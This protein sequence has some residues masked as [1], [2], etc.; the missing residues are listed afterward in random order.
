MRISCA[1]FGSCAA[2]IDGH[3]VRVPWLANVQLFIID[4]FFDFT[5]VQGEILRQLIPRF[6]QTIVNLNNDDSNPEIF[7]PFQETIGQLQS[8][9]TFDTVHTQDYTATDR[10]LVIAPR[11]PFQSVEVVMK[12]R[13]SRS[14]SRSEIRYLECGDRDTEIRTIARE[15]KR[16]VLTE[17]YDLA[18]IALVVRERAAYASTISR[19]LLEESLPCNLELRVDAGDVPANRAALKLLLLLEGLSAEETQHDPNR[20]DRGSDQVGIFPSQ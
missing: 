3:V 18:D 7:V 13:K 14:L 6:P 15:V 5:P 20:R 19:V 9:A 8:I 4:G 16:L 17:N 12:F 2:L 1:R 10:R 11:E